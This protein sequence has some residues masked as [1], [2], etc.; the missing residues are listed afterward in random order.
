M[1]GL[2]HGPILGWVRSRRVLLLM[3]P[4]TDGVEGRRATRA[5]AGAM[6]LLGPC[7]CAAAPVLRPC[8]RVRAQAPPKLAHRAQ[9]V[10]VVVGLLALLPSGRTQ[11]CGTLTQAQICREDCGSCG[12]APCCS[13]EV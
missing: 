5:A 9:A 7:G 8:G 13:L 6:L 11:H 1:I 2:P 10:A 3:A 12:A 4:C